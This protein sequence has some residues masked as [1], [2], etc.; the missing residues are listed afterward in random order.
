M[1]KS[2]V[3]SGQNQEQ[4]L[5]YVE[6]LEMI[7]PHAA[8]I[9]V[10]SEEHWLALPRQHG[11]EPR[12]FLAFT[13]DLYR[14][15]D[16]LLEHG[17]TSVAMES[18]GVYWIPLYQILEDAK[19][20]VLLVNAR[21]VKSVK[22][23]PKT[24]RLDCQWGQRLHSFGLLRGSFR[25]TAEICALRS[26]WRSRDTVLHEA[27]RHVQRMQKALHE[28][29]LKLDKVI[30]DITGK[31]GLAILDSILAG[32]RDAVKLAQLKDPR[33]RKSE[34]EIAE[35]LRGDYRP[36]QLFILEM[37]LK[38]YRH[39]LEQLNA[40]DEQIQLR[41]DLLPKQRAI[42]EHERQANEK[43][44]AR[45]KRRN[46]N[47]PGFDS[48][49]VIH[50]LTGV[51]LGAIPGLSATLLLGLISETGLDMSKWPSDKHFA[52]WLGN[53]P[54]PRISGGKNL[55]THTK[56][57]ASRAARYFRQGDYPT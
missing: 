34:E 54:N 16:W 49:S 10:G 56:S 44:H 37:E 47:A 25:P 31:T 27:R 35:A 17:V 3:P 22:G 43:E 46:P 50:Q 11:Q 42:A 18:T 30:S 28:M 48:R 7:N 38:L 55:G 36:D 26:L 12:R 32:E 20:E 19:L 1:K 23:R 39:L 15:R 8:F 45:Y 9:D 21:D 4:Q 24:D 41:L 5:R 53:C 13:S 29:N 6:G 57:C 51:D 40:Y 14:I 2:T 33:V 52:S